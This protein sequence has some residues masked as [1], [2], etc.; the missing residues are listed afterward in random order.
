LNKIKIFD[1]NKT[2]GP[3][4]V[5]SGKCPDSTPSSWRKLSRRIWRTMM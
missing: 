5:I 3:S 1:K 2:A 4:L